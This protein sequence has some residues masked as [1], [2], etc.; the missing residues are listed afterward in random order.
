MSTSDMLRILLY[1]KRNT[2]SDSHGHLD[3]SPFHKFMNMHETYHLA[4]WP[5]ILTPSVTCHN[6]QDPH[7]RQ[8]Y[9]ILSL[10]VVYPSCMS[11]FYCNKMHAFSEQMKPSHNRVCFA[12]TGRLSGL[13]AIQRF[14][15]DISLLAFHISVIL[16]QLYFCF[17]LNNCIRTVVYNI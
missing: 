6:C 9:A 10:C 1:W 5:G 11:F 17:V 3:I 16:L 15:T 7:Q 2:R 8:H 4:M 12:D 14:A 13:R